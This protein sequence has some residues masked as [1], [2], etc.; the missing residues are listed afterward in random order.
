LG[1]GLELLRSS[2]E[3][4]TG[5]FWVD[6][7]GR[8]VQDLGRSPR[9]CYV[10]LTPRLGNTTRDRGAETEKQ[11]HTERDRQR[12]ETDRERERENE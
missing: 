7:E 9:S 10:W 2:R 8:A 3:R 4:D 5:R 1:Q 6:W 12:G 11:R